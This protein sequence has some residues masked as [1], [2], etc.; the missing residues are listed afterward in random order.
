MQIRG[1]SIFSTPLLFFF[2]FAIRLCIVCFYTTGDLFFLCKEED[3]SFINLPIILDNDFLFLFFFFLFFVSSSSSSI[4]SANLMVFPFSSFC[5]VW[6]TLAVGV[7]AVV[8]F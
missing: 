7:G 4:L 8:W 1:Y 3:T 2:L 6:W 5:R